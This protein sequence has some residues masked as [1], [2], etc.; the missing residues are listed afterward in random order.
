L[1]F[2]AFSA[3]IVISPIFLFLEKETAGFWPAA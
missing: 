1:L 2:S 3:D